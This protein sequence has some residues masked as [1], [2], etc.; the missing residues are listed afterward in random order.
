M[1][2]V[3]HCILQFTASMSICNIL[4]S[5][6]SRFIFCDYVPEYARSVCLRFMFSVYIP[7]VYFDFTS[8]VVKITYQVGLSG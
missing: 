4:N 7:Y 6:C 3:N 2:I 1:Q 8:L 5:L